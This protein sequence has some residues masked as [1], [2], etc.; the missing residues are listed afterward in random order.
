MHLQVGERT[1]YFIAFLDEYSRAIVH[2]E[3]L[4]GMDGLTSSLAAQR[5]IETLPRA[6]DGR[7]PVTPEIR[8]DNGSGFISQEFHVVLKENGL[9]HHRIQPR[10]PEENGLIERFY[11]TV[12]EGL[13]G[14]ELA[15]YVA[16]ERVMDRLAR[17]YNHERLHSALG[18]LP[19]WESYRGD[20][21]G[22]F[23]ERRAQLFEARDRRRERN[24]QLRQGS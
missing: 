17:R 13:E 8:T 22:R 16:A 6:D 14:E 4:L 19:P 11:R 5:A 24:L 12:R 1:Y 9:G 7:P 23:E 3:L 15:D 18:D 10:C 20:P 21:E 2:H